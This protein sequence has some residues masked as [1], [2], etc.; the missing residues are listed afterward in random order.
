MTLPPKARYVVS[1]GQTRKHH[2][3]WP[4]CERQVPPAMWGCL[5]HWKRL[6][7]DLQ[8]RIWQAY[9]PGQE[10]DMRPSEE[11]IQVARDVQDW[12]AKNATAPLTEDTLPF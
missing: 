8:T 12:I 6:P 11:Y 3:H 9:Q 5:P 4:A 7:K 2:C 1:Q 10:K